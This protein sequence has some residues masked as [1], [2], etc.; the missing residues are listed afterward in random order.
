M[1]T[2]EQIA[3][4]AKEGKFNLHPNELKR[5]GEAYEE[6]SKDK[7]NLEQRVELQTNINLGLLERDIGREARIQE[8][9]LYI[10]YL[11]DRL[12]GYN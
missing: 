7:H 11:Q 8:L 1:L 6:L 3:H 10:E 9:K 2:L 12:G 5:L 4:I